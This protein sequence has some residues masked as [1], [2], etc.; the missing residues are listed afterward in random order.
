MKRLILAIFLSLLFVI[1]VDAT[2]IEVPVVPES[3]ADIM[4][5]NTDSFGD[6]LLELLVKSIR[7]VRPDLQEAARISVVIIFTGMLFSLLPIISEKLNNTATVAAMTT[8]S[9]VMFRHTDAM[10]SLATN[11]VMEIFE[12]G[13]L[14]CQVMTTALAAQGGITTSSAL[15]VGTTAFITFLGALMSRF[16]VPMI[17]IFL[18]FGLA[19]CAVGNE[20]LKNASISIKN[21]LSWFLKTVIGI[22]TAYLSITGVVSGTTDQAALKASKVA[23]SSLVPVVGGILSDSSESVLLS[24][25]IIKNAAGIYGILAVLA[26]FVGPFLKIGTHYLLLKASSALCAVFCS[27]QITS[28]TECFA[29][30]MGLLVGIM[31]V[32]CIMVLISTICYLKGTGNG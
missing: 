17:Y 2:Q 9:T 15:Y 1:P 29:A 20:F 8:I 30:A 21:L 28:V 24:M 11:T 25:G 26:V 3:A 4:P 32:G 5:E 22:F 18:A 6:A 19:S 27:K 13:K 31:A 12:Y 14:L 23:I 7:K 10:V 16:L